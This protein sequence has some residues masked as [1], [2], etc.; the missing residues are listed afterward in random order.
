MDPQ[1][2]AKQD[3]NYT[4]THL[5][6]PYIL[7]HFVNYAQQ[8]TLYTL[9]IEHGTQH[10]S[11]HSLPHKRQPISGSATFSSNK[12]SQYNLKLPTYMY[13]TDPALLTPCSIATTLHPPTIYHAHQHALHTQQYPPNCLPQPCYAHN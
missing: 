7:C 1:K 13:H 11:L 5:H 12:I 9:L 6:H 8:K 10:C 3:G 4:T 2:P